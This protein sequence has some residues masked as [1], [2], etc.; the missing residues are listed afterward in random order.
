M[1]RLCWLHRGGGELS[2]G[3]VLSLTAYHGLPKLVSFLPAR[4]IASVFR[5]APGFCRTFARPGAE[6]DELEYWPRPQ[7]A[8]QGK[9]AVSD[10]YAGDV[11][12]RDCF[13]RLSEDPTAQLVDVRTRAEWTFVGLPLI[14]EGHSP[15]LAEWQTFPAMTTDEHFAQRLGQALRE[16]GADAQTP[17]YFLCRSGARSR[18]AAATMTAA[19]YRNC[20]NVA[21]G[22]EGSIDENGH[23][24][25]KEGW[26]AEGLP[27]AQR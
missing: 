25:T 20:F 24:G 1:G 11:S 27:W 19:G 9:Y 4:S 3:G 16:R 14:D 10:D 23:R 2:G 6:W 26:K 22:F 12:S 8:E 18:A 13:Q 15:I 21:D 17:I 7:G 5:P